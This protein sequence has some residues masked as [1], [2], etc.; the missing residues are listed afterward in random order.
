MTD[1][2]RVALTFDAE[3]PDRPH[4][5]DHAGWVLD[6]L[7]RLDVRATFFLQGRWV[8]AFPDVAGRVPAEGH[9]VGNHSFYHARMPLLSHDGFAEDVGEA[10]RVIQGVTG[11]DPRPWLRF[12]FGAG[13][14]SAELLER[15]RAL[16][17]RHVGW[18]VEVYEWDP[19]R[20]S[21][22][23][24]NRAVEG[25]IARGDGAIVLLHTWPD[26]VA[27]ALAEIVERL[28]EQGAKFVRVDEL[29]L[30][31]DMTPV[32]LPQPAVPTPAG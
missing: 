6:E 2:L 4:H 20:S 32:A 14:D 13:A 11:V 26:P 22:E 17:Y 9:L 27:P 29:D 18:D 1:E 5:G 31:P 16:G 3:H 8:E 24:A 28:R 7:A 15:L 25:V 19:G 30:A 21:R 12:P 10:A 23:V